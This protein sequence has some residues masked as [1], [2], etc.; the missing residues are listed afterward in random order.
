MRDLGHQQ[1]PGQQQEAGRE[2]DSQEA[3]SEMQSGGGEF[4]LPHS[5]AS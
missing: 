3:V 5:I 2:E 1:F 4:I